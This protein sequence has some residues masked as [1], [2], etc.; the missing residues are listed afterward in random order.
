MGISLL[1]AGGR[2][3]WQRITTSYF[4]PA[5]DKLGPVERRLQ[6]FLRYLDGLSRMDTSLLNAKF[7]VLI[8]FYRTA[9]ENQT[10]F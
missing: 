2:L 8:G 1:L 4:E 7:K 9:P 6:L 5:L 10:L 3:L